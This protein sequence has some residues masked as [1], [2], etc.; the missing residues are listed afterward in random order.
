MG[1]TNSTRIGQDNAKTIRGYG[2]AKIELGQIVDCTYTVYE[3]PYGVAEKPIT[4]NPTSVNPPIQSTNVNKVLSNTNSCVE[5][6]K[7]KK[8]RKPFTTTEEQVINLCIENGYKGMN[9]TEGEL[10]TWFCEVA[11]ND[12]GTV[13]YKGRAITSYIGLKSI[14]R[15]IDVSGKKFA[16]SK[17]KRSVRSTANEGYF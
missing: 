8:K 13:V 10:A 5:E 16:T 2:I 15:S 12:D 3:T 4:E 11:L 7:P 6:E 14:L 1:K 17:P 9:S